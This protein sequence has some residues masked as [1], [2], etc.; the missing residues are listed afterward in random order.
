[1]EGVHKAPSLVFLVKFTVLGLMNP[2][3]F[4]LVVA[5]L[6]YTTV[7]LIALL[8]GGVEEEEVTVDGLT[9]SFTS[10][11]SRDGVRSSCYFL[12]RIGV[13]FP[14]VVDALGLGL[15]RS[16]TMDPEVPG[17]NPDPGPTTSRINLYNH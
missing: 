5:L 13:Y 10:R 15:E 14:S 3:S 2:L 6:I 17:S 7:A 1:M 16:G 8:F 4:T 12:E 9:V 11:I